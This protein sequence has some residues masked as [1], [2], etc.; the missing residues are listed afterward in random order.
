M[1]QAALLHEGRSARFFFMD[2][3]FSFEVSPGEAGQATVELMKQCDTVA[4]GSVDAKVLG[5]R[6]L[7]AARKALA[8]CVER[9]WKS[10]DIDQLRLLVERDAAQQV[11]AADERPASDGGARS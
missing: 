2:G 6:V 8:V 11:D 10:P 3:P 5:S 4:M 9:G 7:G 1:Q